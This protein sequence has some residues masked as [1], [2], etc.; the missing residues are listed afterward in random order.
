[1]GEVSVWEFSGYEPYHV[2]Y[3]LFI[4]DANCISIV[5]VSLRDSTDVQLSQIIFWLNFI[6]TRL[7][8]QQTFGNHSASS[9]SFGCGKGGN[10]TCMSYIL[11]LGSSMHHATGG[12]A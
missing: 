8:P 7:A 12:V 2:T 4:G 6:R 1:V 5:V 11:R 3:D 10:V 9:T